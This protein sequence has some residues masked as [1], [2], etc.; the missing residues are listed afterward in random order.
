MNPKE[1]KRMGRFSQLAVAAA[2]DAIDQS[3]FLGK[4]F[5]FM[6]NNLN[7]S[8]INVCKIFENAS[9]FLFE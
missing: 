7:I 9:M 1:A 5:S 8:I 4:I 3:K 2:K 6:I